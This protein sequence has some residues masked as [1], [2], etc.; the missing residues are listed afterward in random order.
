MNLNNGVLRFTQNNQ[1]AITIRD[2][3]INASGRV[4]NFAA[5]SDATEIDGKQVIDGT[6]CTLTKPPTKDADGNDLYLAS[7]NS[8]CQFPSSV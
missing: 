2:T 3:R 4:F 7:G 5:N 1:Q 8:A 6:Q